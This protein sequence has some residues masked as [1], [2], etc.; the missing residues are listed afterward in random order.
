MLPPVRLE[1]C[2]VLFIPMVVT[3]FCYWHFVHVV[4]SWAQLGPWKCWRAVGLVTVTLFK[5]L[6]CLA[7]YNVSHVAGFFH[8]KSQSWQCAQCCS[9]LSM[10]ALTPSFPIFPPELS[11]KP[12]MKGYRGYRAWVDK[13]WRTSCRERKWELKYGQCQLHRRLNLLACYILAEES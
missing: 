8:R 3:I 6:V 4:L 1:L 13:S 11:T 7:P 5:F 2:L 12:L 9:V 10:L